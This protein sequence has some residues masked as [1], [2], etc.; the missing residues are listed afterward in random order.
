MYGRLSLLM[1]IKATCASVSSTNGNACAQ[2]DRLNL[3]C[4]VPTGGRVWP[5]CLQ[6]LPHGLRWYSSSANSGNNSSNSGNNDDGSSAS[7]SSGDATQPCDGAAA[8]DNHAYNAAFAALVA[9][10]RGTEG[11]KV[12]AASSAKQ[13]PIGHA[14]PPG[15]S[16]TSGVLWLSNLF[17]AQSSRY[18]LRQALYNRD[19]LKQRLDDMVTKLGALP[20]TA[21]S[22]AHARLP[23][24][25]AHGARLLVTFARCIG[26][27]EQDARLALWALPQIRTADSPRALFAPRLHT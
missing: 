5:P 26:E 8:G 12:S 22:H 2:H 9:N 10:N 24:W 14:T 16:R 27:R 1:P 21:R 13:E 19:Y 3:S 20:T 25:R 7:S 6:G 4:E 23:L 18:D 15:A 11:D 17:P